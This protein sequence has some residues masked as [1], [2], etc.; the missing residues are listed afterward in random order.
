[1]RDL[2]VITLRYGNVYGP[3]QDPA[4]DAGVVAIFC[5]R[6]LAGLPPTIFGDGRQTRDYVFVRDIVAANLAAARANSVRN[7]VFNVGTGQ[8]V[9]V[10]E[11]LDAVAA[12]ADFNFVEPLMLPARPGEVLRSCLDIT[13]AR[14]ELHLASPTP[15]TEGLA[16]TMD[17]MR[18]FT[19]LI[20][21]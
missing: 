19:G 14:D 9:S 11:L 20:S 18:E 13:R 8:E 3:R 10:L 16:G 7:S 12:A 4:G 17:W 15:L 2:D 5:S 6:V 21:Q 1:M